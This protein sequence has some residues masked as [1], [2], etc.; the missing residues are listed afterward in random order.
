MVSSRDQHQRP[1]SK[2]E[3]MSAAPLK[4]LGAGL[5]AERIAE[6][7]AQYDARYIPLGY[8][9]SD[10]GDD[11][12]DHIPLKPSGIP[13]FCPH[14]GVSLRPA[15]SLGAVISWSDTHIGVECRACTGVW[16]R[17][18]SARWPDHYDESLHAGSWDVE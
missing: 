5:T 18:R 1:S 12:L 8:P 15:R 2:V 4:I 13:E 10:F 9:P 14:C 17:G 11:P 6:V 16:A 7:R 3:V